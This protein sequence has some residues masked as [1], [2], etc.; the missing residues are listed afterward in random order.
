M[1]S[2]KILS[3]KEAAKVILAVKK[4][5]IL[6]HINPDADTVGTAAALG[7]LFRTLG[8][9]PSYISEDDIPKRLEFI[10]KD[11]PRVKN[12]EGCEL[13][14]VDVA[15]PKQGGV[16]LSEAEKTVLMID[17]HKIGEPFA[18]GY[19]IPDASSAAEVLLDII[20]ELISM[21]KASLT[22]DIAEPLFAAMCSDTGGFRFSSATPK[23]FRAAA[24]LIETGIDHADISH[25]LFF[26]K[27][28]GQ[29]RAEGLISEKAELIENT[30]AIASVTE[31]EMR[32][33]N[34]FKEDF[35][36]AI[37]VIRS[38]E[39]AQI[40]VFIREL[41]NGSFKASLRST[42]K[43]VAEVA[44]RFGG[45]GHIRAAGCTLCA[46]DINE[47]K[48]IIISALKISKEI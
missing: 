35:A 2:F 24:R 10:I 23:T 14:A 20:D 34:L 29:I 18:D 33:L 41:D 40:A 5:L 31:S 43:N 42:G 48:D 3:A 26:S 32:E 11:L 27:S 4:P 9:N 39:G 7:S 47:A 21:G 1:S 6:I 22:K 17:H 16:P 46:K 8:K 37:D 13:I 12:S 30:C 45:G 44:Q 25:K 38:I 28:L 36:C 15:S 19:I